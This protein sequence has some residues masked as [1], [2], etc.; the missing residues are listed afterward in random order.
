MQNDLNTQRFIHTASDLVRALDDFRSQL[1]AVAALAAMSGN[2]DHIRLLARLAAV[3][4]GLRRGQVALTT[5]AIP[6][7]ARLNEMN[8]KIHHETADPTG[9]ENT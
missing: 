2:E 1:C 4:E 6:I 8:L 7:L 5:Y 9:S 3:E